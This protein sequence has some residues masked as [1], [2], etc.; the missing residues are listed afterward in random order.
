MCNAMRSKAA[1]AYETMLAIP[2]VDCK[3]PYAASISLYPSPNAAGCARCGSQL[4]ARG[5]LK[6]VERS[7]FQ[8]IR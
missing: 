1:C 5:Y 4:S 3:C 6:Q 7:A 8:Q 2:G